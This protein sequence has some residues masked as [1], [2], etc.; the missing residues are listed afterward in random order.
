M[1]VFLALLVSVGMLKAEFTVV[2]RGIPKAEIAI[3]SPDPNGV[4]KFAAQE[5]QYHIQEI[6]GASLPI[7]LQKSGKRAQIRLSTSP[8]PED[9][10]A[11]GDTDGFAVRQRGMNLIISGNHSKGVLNGVYKLLYR[12]TDIIWAHPNP[13]FGT[14]FTKT[15]DLKFQHT[16]YREAP[17]FTLRGW[18]QN[19][20]MAGADF[21]VRNCANWITPGDTPASGLLAPDS[22]RLKTGMQ[23]LG[24]GGGHNITNVFI[25][26][27]KYFK[28][29]PEYFPLI[30]GRRRQPKEFRMGG[31]QLCF[32]NPDM[33]RAFLHEAE[34][35]MKQF[36]QYEII[37]IMAQDNWN[38]CNCEECLKPLRLADGKYLTHKDEVFRSTQY[39]QWLNKIADELYKKHGWETMTLAYFFTEVPPKCSLSEHIHI[40]YAPI[41]KN[42]KYP[43]TAPENKKIL[44][45]TLQWLKLTKKF[46]WREYY[47]LT[48]IFPRPEDRIAVADWQHL[49]TLGVR[50]TYSEMVSPEAKGRSNGEKVWDINAF[51]F[52]V[53]I[54]ASWDTERGIDAWRRE[55]LNRF[56][57]SGGEAVGKFF[58]LIEQEWQKSPDRSECNDYAGKRWRDAILI[59]G[60]TGKCRNLLKEAATKTLH[61]KSKILL[62]RLRSVFEDQVRRCN[63][64]P[65]PAL[66]VK[67]APVFDP[68]FRKGDWKNAVPITDF[69]Q[70]NESPAHTRTT[71]RVLVDHTNLYVGFQCFDPNPGKIHSAR[72]RRR[73]LW[74][75]GDLVE[76]F[77][78]GKTR[79]GSAKT[80]YQFSVDPVGNLRD[81]KNS[82]VKRDTKWNTKILVK[83]SV[84]SSGWSAFLSLPLEKLDLHLEKDEIKLTFLRYYRQDRRKYKN[85][86]TVIR[87]GC[88]A[89]QPDSYGKLTLI[90]RKN[91]PR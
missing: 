66:F 56:F 57:G 69:E 65:V 3:V 59:P 54:N 40:C 47:G 34:N 38:C 89:H 42:A 58:S 31:V 51:Y 50:K 4:L 14:I 77:I 52:W 83:T 82:G 20:R 18:Q 2:D 27:R 16:D 19:P 5:L 32:T 1:Y 15:P 67:Q 71:V 17:D 70:I 84:T 21:L 79:N 46:Y 62:E 63:P 45:R 11:L 6:S 78:S 26:P 61:P 68:E 86:E 72:Q 74:P 7:T 88:S 35:K 10:E 43:I 85:A 76:L 75:I 13:E 60:H 37:R 48:G 49:K 36:P 25:T 8:E 28:E 80:Y 53:M 39:F 87:Q 55:Y 44:E 24:F 64:L 73:D 12:N 90:G 23:F 41:Y 30:D 91:Q 33:T 22:Y 9:A 81:A 29:H